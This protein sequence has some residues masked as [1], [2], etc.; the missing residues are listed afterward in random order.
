MSHNGYI[1]S[2]VAQEIYGVVIENNMVNDAT[3]EQ[4]RGHEA[5]IA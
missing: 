5:I 3:T 2:Q 4:L 1:S